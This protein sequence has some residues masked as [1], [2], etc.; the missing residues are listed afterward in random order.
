MKTTLEM[1][2]T[3]TKIN[4]I[5]ENDFERS[6]MNGIQVD[7]FNNKTTVTKSLVLN[8]PVGNKNFYLSFNIKHK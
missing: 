1:N 6:I 8:E 7:E 4:I 2:G 3:E 5:P